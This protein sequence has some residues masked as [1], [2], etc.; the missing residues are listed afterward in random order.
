MNFESLKINV[1]KLGLP[2]VLKKWDSNK[3]PR[4]RDRQE[5][6]QRVP[7][8]IQQSVT[9]GNGKICRMPLKMIEVRFYNYSLLSPIR[10]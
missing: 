1:N 9:R 3:F 8:F 5:L 10:N 2:Q 6:T 4:S 7:Q